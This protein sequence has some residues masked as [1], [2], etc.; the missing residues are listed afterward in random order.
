MEMKIKTTMRHHLKLVEWLPP[1]RTPTTTVGKDVK[2]RESSYAFQWEC[3]LVQPLWKTM[4]VSQKTKMG[5][6]YDPAILL[7]GYIWEE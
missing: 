1:S 6:P 4:G 3:K 7:L 2:K 5:V